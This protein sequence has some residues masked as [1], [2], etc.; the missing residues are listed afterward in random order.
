MDKLD[1]VEMG[2]CVAALAI[3]AYVVADLDEP[4][5]RGVAASR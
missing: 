2:R 5:A 3:M 4:L 1:P